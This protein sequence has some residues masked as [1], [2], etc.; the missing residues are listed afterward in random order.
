MTM[1]IVSKLQRLNQVE[2]PTQMHFSLYDVRNACQPEI[3]DFPSEVVEISIV[4]KASLMGYPTSESEVNFGRCR[5]G[6]LDETLTLT[7]EDGSKHE[8]LFMNEKKTKYA[9]VVEP[10]KSRSKRYD[11]QSLPA[12]KIRLEDRIGVDSVFRHKTTGQIIRLEKMDDV[13]YGQMYTPL[14]PRGPSFVDGAFRGPVEEIKGL[15]NY[16]GHGVITAE[17]INT[18]DLVYKT[19]TAGKVRLGW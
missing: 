6:K 3:Y 11:Y 1:L 12:I 7:L 17:V 5:G 18:W 8:V 15:G 19:D 13:R 10:K 9:V 14:A 16:Y 2:I 4:R